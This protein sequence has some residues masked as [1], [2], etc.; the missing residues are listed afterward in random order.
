MSVMDGCGNS[1]VRDPKTGKI[2]QFSD[3]SGLTPEGRDH[4]NYRIELLRDITIANELGIDYRPLD[5]PEK[6]KDGE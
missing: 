1:Y 2:V 6:K 3:K 5:G 4:M